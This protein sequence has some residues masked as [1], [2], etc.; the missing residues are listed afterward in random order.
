PPPGQR[1]VGLPFPAVQRGRV[2]AEPG[3]L[4]VD[5]AE[6]LRL[7]SGRRHHRSGVRNSGGQQQALHRP[8]NRRGKQSGRCPYPHPQSAGR[9]E[10]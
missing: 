4:G 10:P 8:Q 3:G 6:F 5:P 2:R 9:H 1:P 7:R